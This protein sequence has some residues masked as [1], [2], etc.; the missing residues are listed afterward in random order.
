MTPPHAAQWLTP[1][2]ILSPG[3]QSRYPTR[4]LTPA[5]ADQPCPKGSVAPWRLVDYKREME[6]ARAAAAQSMNQPPAP[7]Q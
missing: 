2:N 6:Q 3:F 5:E 1:A 4:L 7:S